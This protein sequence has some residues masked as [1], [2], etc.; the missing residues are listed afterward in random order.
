MYAIIT[1]NT[2]ARLYGDL[3]LRR[4][5]PG[6][7]FSIPE[8]ETTK[9]RETKQ[10]L[11]DML[12]ESGCGRETTIV[13]MGGGVIL[14]LAG[15]L[16]ATFCRGVP[17]ILVPTTLLAMVDASVGGKC[18]VNTPH[19]KNLIGAMYPPQKI[20]TNLQFLQTLPECEMRCGLVELLKHGLIGDPTILKTLSIFDAIEVKRRIVSRDLHEKGLRRLLNLG[21]TIGH[22]L[23]TLSNYT[24]RH[25][26]AVATGISVEARIAFTMG[27]LE[28]ESFKTIISL[29][30]PGHLPYSPNELLSVMRHDKKAQLQEPRFVMLK[31]IGEPHEFGGDFCTTVPSTLLRGV[32]DDLY[33]RR[34]LASC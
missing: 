13:A 21:H 19:G 5:Y 17:L 10:H 20:I 28:K 15:F 18:G 1:D 3:A 32:L 24:L 7:L 2:V 22:A 16:A 31:K 9:S 4:F 6:K 12:F 34:T 23:E 30:G 14:D 29:F 11:E 33:S 26:D 25:G 8:G 27:I